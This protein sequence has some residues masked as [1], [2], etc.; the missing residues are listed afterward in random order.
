MYSGMTG[1]SSGGPWFRNFD[2]NWG[3][4]NGHN[5]FVYT[6]SPAYMY[7]PYYGNQVAS[8]YNAVRYQTS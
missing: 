4:V 8:L 3:Y 5:D 7:S 1:G 2:G 6:N